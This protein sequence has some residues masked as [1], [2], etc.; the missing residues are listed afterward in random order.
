MY[1]VRERLDFVIYQIVEEYYTI[2]GFTDISGKSTDVNISINNSEDIENLG[3]ILEGLS[4]R[5]KKATRL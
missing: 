2:L 1:F 4:I 3:K 5:R